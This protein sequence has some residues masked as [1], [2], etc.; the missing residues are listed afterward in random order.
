MLA[1][2]VVLGALIGPSR[3]GAESVIERSRSAEWVPVIPD[4]A[5]YCAFKST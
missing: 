2:D 4:L 3:C 1:I 5:V